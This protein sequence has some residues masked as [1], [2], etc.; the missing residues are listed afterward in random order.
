MLSRLCALRFG[1][2]GL[3]IA[4]RKIEVCLCC[5]VVGGDVEAHG[6]EGD[7]NKQ[8]PADKA[9]VEKND[10]PEQ[11]LGHLPG[12]FQTLCGGEIDFV[13]HDIKREGIAHKNECG[14]D[15]TDDCKDPHD[16]AGHAEICVGDRQSN[17]RD[18][19][20]GKQDGE[21]DRKQNDVSEQSARK[22]T[23][24]AVD[25]ID[26]LRC[27]IC[28]I[29]IIGGIAA[30]YGPEGEQEPES[31]SQRERTEQDKVQQDGRQ[32]GEA[33]I[34][35]H[36]H[37][38]LLL[39]LSDTHVILLLCLSRCFCFLTNTAKSLYKMGGGG[40][41]KRTLILWCFNEIMNVKNN[42]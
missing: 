8:E 5:L 29:H 41:P 21:R 1:K 34:V 26:T 35:L 24:T 11:T 7:D 42:I 6:A 30:L 16:G 18:N 32:N 23:E 2:G 40:N 3:L 31:K 12:L 39:Q 17:D 38:G 20:R 4:K 33:V 13:I 22:L 9:E 19:C 25:G 27:V 15:K 14:G 10:L 36:V 28:N 37:L